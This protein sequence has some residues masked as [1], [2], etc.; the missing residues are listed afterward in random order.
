MR[1][2]ARLAATIF[3]PPPTV[4]LNVEQ[5]QPEKKQLR[6]DSHGPV[7]GVSRIEFV[8]VVS[9]KD[10]LRV[11]ASEIIQCRRC[12]RLREYCG[13]IAREKR[14]AFADWEYW[15]KPVPGF[16]DVRAGIW[17]V[18][19]APGAHG[20]NRT[21]RVFTGDRSG[22]FLFAALHR[23][24]MANQPESIHR[25]DG[26][27]L[28]GVYIS[29]AARCAPPGNKPLPVE[30]AN[31]AGYLDREWEML[32]NVRIMLALGKIGWDATMALARRRGCDFPEGKK[33]FGHGALLRLSGNRW[34]LGSYHVSQQNTFTGKLTAGMFDEILRRCTELLNQFSSRSDRGV[35]GSSP[36]SSISI[37]S[38]S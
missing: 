8:K 32:K 27:R 4:V 34:M 21:G 5:S 23:A 31:C 25:D 36:E 18:G 9:P 15:G 17:I 26:L 7:G 19:L 3:A 6:I 35:S 10:S 37:I 24:G 33:G 20:A 2:D 14:N 30:L 11:L 1:A 38:R 29:A 28:R 22:D 13:Q 12:T 16:G